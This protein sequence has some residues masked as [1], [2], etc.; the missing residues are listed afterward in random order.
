MTTI[1]THEFKEAIR[2]LHG[3]KD[4]SY[5]DAWK[6][7]GETMSIMANIA[8]KIDR[9]E[10]ATG[11]AP[12]TPGE[13]LLD[14]AVDLLVYSLKY[15]TFLADQSAAVAA[16]LYRNSAIAP[17]YSDGPSGFEAL[18]DQLNVTPMDSDSA[19]NALQATQHV[20]SS[21]AELEAC[22]QDR[23]APVR[24]RAVKVIVLAQAAVVLLGSLIY[25]APECY[26]DFL[27]TWLREAG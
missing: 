1:D 10:Y 5:R 3:H 27:M 15:Q 17:P 22:F 13:N 16:D 6:K 21:F 9:L 24:E 12:A 11:G 25:Q 26:R 8:R 18:L 19:R 14:T 23:P 7:R 4:A 2:R 20:L